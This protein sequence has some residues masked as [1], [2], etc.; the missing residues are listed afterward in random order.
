[1]WLFFPVNEF[2]LHSRN[3]FST[4]VVEFEAANKSMLCH[5]IF[6]ARRLK[7]LESENGKLKKLL[8]SKC[9]ANVG[10]SAHYYQEGDPEYVQC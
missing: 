4:F 9:W 10:A 5:S 3:F 1:M 6:K 2:L 8:L 7:D